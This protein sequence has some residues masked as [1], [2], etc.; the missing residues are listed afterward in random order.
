MHSWSFCS[1][2][3]FLFVFVL[4]M[5]VVMVVLVM[6]V[7]LLW[8]S[9]SSFCDSSSFSSPCS[10]SSYSSPCF[11]FASQKND[12]FFLSRNLDSF[13]YCELTKPKKKILEKISFQTCK[14]GTFLYYLQD[15][16]LNSLKTLLCTCNDCRS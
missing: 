11:I 5:I 16:K 3:D 4:G 8:C 10:S 2:P 7:L 15:Q 12:F 14:N 9:W 1:L 13:W 6:V